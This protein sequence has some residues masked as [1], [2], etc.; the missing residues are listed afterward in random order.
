MRKTL[1]IENGTREVGQELGLLG[2][3]LGMLLFGVSRAHLEEHVLFLSSLQG[4]SV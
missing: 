3:D 2:A 1:T 4:Q